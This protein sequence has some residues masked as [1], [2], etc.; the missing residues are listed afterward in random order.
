MTGDDVKVEL[1]DN[2]LVVSGEKSIK[3]EHVSK[4]KDGEV[5]VWRQ[6]RKK[7][8]FS[9]SFQLPENA[10]ADG[11]TAKMEHGVLTVEVG[12]YKRQIMCLIRVCSSALASC[13]RTVWMVAHPCSWCIK[14]CQ[15]WSDQPLHTRGTHAERSTTVEHHHC[16]CCY[17][18]LLMPLTDLTHTCRSLSKT[19]LRSPSPRGFAWTLQGTINS[20]NHCMHANVMLCYCMPALQGLSLVFNHSVQQGLL[21]GRMCMYQ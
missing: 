14:A 11:I 5:K 21:Q 2:V 3:K 20:E 8:K 7:R 12:A 15:D 9:R 16:H 17:Q 18:C 4:N 1:H 10:K 13:R 6:E 19:L